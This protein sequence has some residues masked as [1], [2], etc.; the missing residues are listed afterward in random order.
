MIHVDIR[1]MPAIGAGV[2]CAIGGICLSGLIS[3]VIYPLVFNDVEKRG[4][5]VLMLIVLALAFNAVAVGLFVLGRRQL[6]TH[7]TFLGPTKFLWNF[8][9]PAAWIVGFLIPLPIVFG[10]H[11]L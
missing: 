1:H 5:S 8:A 11:F 4:M 10:P 7:G 3:K 2:I 6:Q 9:M